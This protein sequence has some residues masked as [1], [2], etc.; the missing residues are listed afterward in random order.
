MSSNAELHLTYKI[1]NAPLNVFPFPHLYIRD[2]FPADYYA[3]IQ[4]MLPDPARMVTISEA[5]PVP[6]GA[7][8]ER[9]VLTFGGEQ[10]PEKV[11]YLRQDSALNYSLIRPRVHRYCEARHASTS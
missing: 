10:F 1:A 7:Y 11:P 8:K 5:R 4:S 6:K 9:F 2:A 3:R